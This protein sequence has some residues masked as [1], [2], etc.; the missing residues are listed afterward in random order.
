MKRKLCVTTLIMCILCIFPLNAQ[1]PQ[2][3]TIG[4]G[5]GTSTVLPDNT[6][7]N[8]S[9]SQQIY[10]A[11]ELEIP[12]GSEIKSISFYVKDVAGKKSINRNFSIN[13][14]ETNTSSLANGAF[15]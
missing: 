15:V 13:L 6:S 9:V 11:A 2:T 4:N 5:G 1:T 10:T 3:K 7:A 14:S 8:Y 12:V